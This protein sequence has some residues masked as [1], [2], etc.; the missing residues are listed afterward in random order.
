MS[1]DSATTTTR[2]PAGTDLLGAVDLDVTGMTCAA[3]A[4][5]IERK[6]NKLDGVTAS[7]NYATEK[8]RVRLDS[9]RDVSELIATIEATGYGAHLPDPEAD[10]PDRV[11]YLRKRL[12]VARHLQWR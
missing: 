5:R 11:G 12:I 9:P 8:A 7:V 10:E 6:L 4:S 2:R 3:C 1:P